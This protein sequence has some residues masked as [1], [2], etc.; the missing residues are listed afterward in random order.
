MR[1]ALATAA[2]VP[3]EFDDDQL[4][5]EELRARGAEAEF[6]LWDGGVD[7]PAFDLVVIRS[8]WDYT[9]RLDDFLAWAET[10]GDRLRNPPEVVRWNSDKRY[11]ADVAGAGLAV[12]PTTYIGP[13]DDTLDLPDEVIVKPTI[14]AGARDTGRFGREHHDRARALL[15][16]LAAAGRTAMVQ[17]YLASVDAHGETAVVFVAGAPTHVLRKRPVL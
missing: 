9:R 4:L 11:L 5:A 6:A 16:R 14:S 8:T 15:A 10:V 12:V 17:P 2:A 3:P 1:I 13:G 7:W